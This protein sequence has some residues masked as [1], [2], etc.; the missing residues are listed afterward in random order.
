MTIMGV[1]EV[2][3]G[4]WA[5][6]L[7]A[8]AVVLPDSFILPAGATWRLADS[9]LLSRHQRQVSAVAIRKLAVAWGLG[10]VAAEELDVVGMT[11]AVRLAMERAVAAAGY[12]TDRLIIDG[13]FNYLPA[14]SGSEAVVKADGCVPA[15][16]AAS[17]LAKVARD[18]WMAEAADRYPG[19]GFE[20]HVGYGTMQHRQALRTLGVC[21]LHRRSFRPVAAV[22]Q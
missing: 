3:R 4:C 14:V 6:P 10:W 17:I 22:V 18:D 15:V 7:V 9:K 16:S 21:K 12:M 20:R 19:Y 2:G 5:G 1:D 8:G 11:A 13:S